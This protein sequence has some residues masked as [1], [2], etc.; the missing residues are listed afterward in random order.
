MSNPL[1]PL[2]APERS[3]ATFQ[4]HLPRHGVPGSPWLEG[5]CGQRGSPGHLEPVPTVGGQKP[6]PWPGV[7]DASQ[8]LSPMGVVGR[9][10]EVPRKGTIVE[11]ASSG[12]NGLS[13]QLSIAMRDGMLLAL[14][15][16]C[17]QRMN[18]Q[19]FSLRGRTRGRSWEAGGAVSTRGAGE[20]CPERRDLGPCGLS[21]RCAPEGGAVSPR[22]PCG[23]L[24]HGTDAKAALLGSSLDSP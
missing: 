24:S 15:V 9:G 11:G 10:M 1:S 5:P 19:G 18:P 13:S 20:A 2:P 12:E 6:D 7:R 4:H 22:G 17:T 14:A 8:L 16:S 23:L 21:L 3:L